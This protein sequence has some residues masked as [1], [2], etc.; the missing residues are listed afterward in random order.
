ME[1]SVGSSIRRELRNG[2]GKRPERKGDKGKPLK[3]I[4][5][6]RNGTE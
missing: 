1:L 2:M 5:E 6:I 4:L 3:G